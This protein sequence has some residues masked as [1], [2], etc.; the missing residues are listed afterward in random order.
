MRKGGGGV[1][2]EEAAFESTL[3]SFVQ[4]KPDFSLRLSGTRQ[5]VGDHMLVKLFLSPELRDFSNVSATDQ[6]KRR[7]WSLNIFAAQAGT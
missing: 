1:G 6:K 7:L 4:R 5:L 2:G 3:I